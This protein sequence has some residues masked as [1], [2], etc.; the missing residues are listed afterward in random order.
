[1]LLEDHVNSLVRQFAENQGGVDR[2][3]VINSYESLIEIRQPV[4]DALAEIVGD[5]TSPYREAAATLIECFHPVLDS[6]GAL[7]AL[8]AAMKGDDPWLKLECAEAI[9]FIEGE[10]KEVRGIV[11][12]LATSAD[13]ELR[14]KSRNVLETFVGR[15]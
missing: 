13:T 10:T 3:A 8:R 1:M 12:E 2:D 6:S 4:V 9:W 14:R 15:V 5:V 11:E 7:P